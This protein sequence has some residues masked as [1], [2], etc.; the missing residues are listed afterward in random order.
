MEIT[1]IKLNTLYR[2]FQKESALLQVD[3]P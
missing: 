1:G 3:V 2:V